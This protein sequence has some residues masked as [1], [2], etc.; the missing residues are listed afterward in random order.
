[1][2]LLIIG[3][4][5]MVGCNLCV[6]LQIVCW[7]VLVFICVELDL[8]DDVVLCSYLVW[9]CLDGVVYVVGLVGGIQVN[10]VQFV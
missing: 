4:Y 9:Y 8:Q 7:E 3:V 6:Y 2:W 10:I 1:M 5:G